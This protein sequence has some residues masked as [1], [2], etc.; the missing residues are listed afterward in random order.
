MSSLTRHLHAKQGDSRGRILWWACWKSNSGL[1]KYKTQFREKNITAAPLLGPQQR[2]PGLWEHVSQ[3]ESLFPHFFLIL[4]HVLLLKEG[5]KNNCLQREV[6][7]GVSWITLMPAKKDLAKCLH[8]RN[9]FRLACPLEIKPVYL[10]DSL[11]NKSENSNLPPPS[12]SG[13]YCLYCTSREEK[14]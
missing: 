10:P 6:T 8:V 12:L 11:S 3:L 2:P 5:K 1:K 7:D 13:P 14:D 9:L 4:K